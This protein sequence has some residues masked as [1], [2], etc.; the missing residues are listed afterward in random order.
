MVVAWRNESTNINKLVR[1]KDLRAKL[2]W[3]ISKGELTELFKQAEKER[4]D[5]YK[6]EI[7]TERHLTVYF[8]NG[9][10]VEYNF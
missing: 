7:N 5:I 9:T 1:Y 4:T 8:N 3:Y 6:V 10:I 2:A